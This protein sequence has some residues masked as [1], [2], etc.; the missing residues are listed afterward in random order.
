MI[1][2]NNKSSK[3]LVLGLDNSGKT[4][5]VLN[6]IGKTNLLDYISLKPTLGADIIQHEINDSNYSIWDLG[7]QKVYREEY[8]NNFNEYINGASK[9]VYVIDIQDSQRYNLA[10]DYFKKIIEK[11]ENLDSNI[12]ITVFLHKDD[13]LIENSRPDINEQTI[14]HL[15]NEIKKLIP[16]KI[17]YEIYT[18]TIYTIFDKSLKK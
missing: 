14:D 17:Y 18:S 16:Y 4:S 3:I 2:K 9:I 1:E 5:I 7:G 8:L 13:P 15:Y 11:V 6:L 12:E 10:L